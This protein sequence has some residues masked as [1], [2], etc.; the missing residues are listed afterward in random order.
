MNALTFDVLLWMAQ[1]SYGVVAL[2]LASRRGRASW[3]LAGLVA[4][5][6]ALAEATVGIGLPVVI[7]APGPHIAFIA[8][9][10]VLPVLVSTLTSAGLCRSTL[11]V[12]RQRAVIVLVSGV[13]SLVV[14][15]VGMILM[16]WV[17]GAAP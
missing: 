16:F 5:A 15:P 8:S 1:V 17:A 14:Q 4:T 10:A 9:V 3:R 7:A 6:L 13:V 11:A 12:A 2:A